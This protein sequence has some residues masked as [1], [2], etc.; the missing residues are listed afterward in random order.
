MKKLS[1]RKKRKSN[2]TPHLRHLHHHRPGEHNVI[3]NDARQRP[4][5]GDGDVDDARQALGHGAAADGGVERGE[6]GAADEAGAGEAAE[7][8]AGGLVRLE[9]NLGAGNERGGG[10]AG[11]EREAG[12]GREREVAALGARRDEGRGEREDHLGRE[13]RVERRGDGDDG[14]GGADKGLVARL[15]REDGGGRREDAGVREEL[16]GA[17]VGRDADVLEHGGRGHHG[18]GVGEAKV[19]LAGLHGLDAGLRERA[20][21]ENDV[22]LLGLAN[23]GEVLDLALRE[24]EG[25][26]VADGE[27]LEAQSVELGLEVL[28][29]EG[30]G[31]C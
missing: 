3:G 24:A 21:Q 16:G 28:E 1:Q 12:E 6:G 2:P 31:G 9:L 22:R 17:G 14:R 30:A 10:L 27:L 20:L 13:R 23:L 8:G 4:G 29:G 5:A 25:L 7:L 15:D 11:G 19:V 26:E 18:R